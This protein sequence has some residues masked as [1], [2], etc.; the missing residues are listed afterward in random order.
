MKRKWIGFVAAAAMAV[1]MSMTAW[2]AETKIDTVKLEISHEKAPASGD[3]IGS[4]RAK[5]SGDQP[6]TVE[7]AEYMFDDGYHDTWIVGDRPVVL[8]ELTAKNGY[9]F[10]YTSKSHFSL[11]GDGATFKKAKLIDGG[12]QMELQVYLKRIGGTL[13]D[14]QNV[15]WSGTTAYWDYLEGAKSYE[16]RLYRDEKSVITQSTTENSYDFRNQMDREGSY[17]F[18]VRAIASYNNRAGEWSEYSEDYYVDEDDV[19]RYSGDGSGYWQQDGRGRWYAYYGG[20]FPKSMWKF[21][22]NAWYYF[23]NEGYMATGWRKVSGNTYYLGGDGRMLTGWQALEGNWYYFDGSGVMTTDW[24]FVNGRWYYM[25]AQ[26]RMTTGWQKIGGIWYYL[27][28]SGAML[29][30][31]QSIDGKLYYMDSSGAM[32]ANRWTPDGHYVNESGVRVQ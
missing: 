19:W 9:K 8:V 5:V 18:R 23:D 2:A 1:S 31:W 12:T 3:E 10:A 22:D 30:G 20:G 21:I 17:T 29:T 16:V 24:Q 28:G 7:Y 32:Y 4:V 11:S 26:G 14:V 15:E 6:Y 25:N 13:S 27:D